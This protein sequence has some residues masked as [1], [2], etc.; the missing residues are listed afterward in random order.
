MK[1]S[2]FQRLLL[3]YLPVFFVVIA[4]LFVVFFQTLNE[5]NRR[6]AIRANEALARQVISY[7]DN[8]LRS[9]EYHVVRE[10]I[11]NQDLKA[12]FGTDRSDVYANILALGIIEDLKFNYPFVSSVYFV[13][14]KDQYVF[15]DGSL[16]AEQEFPDH[17]FIEQVSKTTGFVKWTGKRTYRA[18]PS[19]AGE[20]V[21]SLV[22]KVPYFVS[23]NSGM[24]VVNVNL[25]KMADAIS[26]MYSS[27][28]SFVCLLDK[29]GL[30]LAESGH[31]DR[32]EVLT[33]YVSPYTGW[34]V[35]SGLVDK[36]I[37]GFAFDFYNIWFFLAV[38]AVMAGAVWVVYVTKRNYT[39][40][41][42]LVSLIETSSLIRQDVAKT[43][44]NEFGFIHEALE[45]LMAETRKIQKQ[46]LEH[47]IREKRHRF[48]EVI[49]GTASMTDGEWRAILGRYKPDAV[50]Q[51]ACVLVLELDRY[52]EFARTYDKKDQSIFKF[53]LSRVVHETAQLHGAAVWAEWTTDRQMAAI[54]WVRDEE[55]L[56]LIRQSVAQTVI[57]WVRK[58]LRFTVT[59]GIG[60]TA[61]RPEEIRQSFASA[62]NLLQ[63]K[64]VLGSGRV[65]RTED[66][67]RNRKERHDY[68]HTVSAF[69]HAF[70]LS[71]PSWRGHL[72][73][74][75]AQIRE[76]VCSHTEI[77][78]L[79]RF[80][81]LNLRR[82]FRE[83]STR[84]YRSVWKEMESGLLGLEDRWETV[85]ELHAGCLVVFESAAEKM[86]KI[87]DSDE[88]RAL[89]G[90]IRKY[91][92]E[93]Y[94][95]PALSLDHL[96]D[97]FHLSAKNISKLFKEEFGENFVDFLIGLRMEHAKKLLKE[98]GKSLQEIGAEVGY[99]NYNSFNRAFKNS[100]GLSP[101]D[102]RKR[103][104][105]SRKKSGF[106]ESCELNGQMEAG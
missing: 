39:P 14:P 49:D 2:W 104:L 55:E 94:T 38:I 78:T 35:E 21:V 56:D 67:D 24:M 79:L 53:V 51:P 66:P 20:E 48:L 44:S 103:F 36:G 42:Q 65:I 54:L 3:S 62:R 34:L 6:E 86:L 100:V 29:E 46:Q 84:E 75:F 64:A 15:A 90:D 7:T 99:Y 68:F 32:K 96:S 95:N 70:R 59:I 82:S 9:I 25:Q 92:E 8:L 52:G 50:D 58:H 80:L 98:T 19:Q 12:F 61:C 60:D 23:A 74:F 26:Q 87:R 28:V 93:H 88:N 77:E 4:I 73:A 31:S 69:V 33:T 63:Y 41:R 105:E 30:V 43:G 76:S 81:H 47:E 5:Q 10:I 89:L 45:Q 16:F 106:G 102:Y 40:V 57:Q 22:Q 72:D 11:T 85:G 97:K 18:Y 13:R 83:L 101:S 27:E 1:N 37:R 17:P 91:I 71:E